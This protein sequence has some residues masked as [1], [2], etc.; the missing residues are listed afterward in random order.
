MEW[1]RPGLG[2]I[3]GGRHVLAM[4]E[5]RGDLDGRAA[6][7][8]DRALSGKRMRE[9]D[10]NRQRERQQTAKPHAYPLRRNPMSPPRS[11]QEG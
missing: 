7:A 3:G 5:M 2:G 9:Q 4:A 11:P 6:D 10:L 8:R 1:A